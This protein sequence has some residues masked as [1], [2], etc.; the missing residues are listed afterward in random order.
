MPGVCRTP[1]LD[2]MFGFLPFFPY[3]SHKTT[4]PALSQHT[5]KI[6][7]RVMLHI[8]KVLYEH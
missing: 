7:M 2:K 5:R 8:F 4:V 3:P 1:F 6:N